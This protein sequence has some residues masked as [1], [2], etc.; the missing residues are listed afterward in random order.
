VILPLHLATPPLDARTRC[1][2]TWPI[3]A[4]PN[5]APVWPQPVLAPT[6][7]SALGL[8]FFLPLAG[9]SSCKVHHVSPRSTGP[10]PHLSLDLGYLSDTAFQASSHLRTRGRGHHESSANCVA[11]HSS[12]FV[13]IS[14]YF[15]SVHLIWGARAQH[16]ANPRPSQVTTISPARPSVLF[17]AASASRDDCKNQLPAGHGLE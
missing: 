4:C 2:C 7:G 6:F 13:L 1:W 11:G 16:L 9:S 3:T 14:L 17:Q 15:P 5:R 8:L 12:P 10:K